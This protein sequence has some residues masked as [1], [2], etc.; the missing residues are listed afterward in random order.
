[1]KRIL[2]TQIRMPHNLELQIHEVEKGCEI[3]MYDLD[4][5]RT[6]WDAG[7]KKFPSFA[8]AHQWAL[9]HQEAAFRP[10]TIYTLY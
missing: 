1:M 9:A 8:S 5:K 7:V 4:T 3:T 2:K 10:G 6:V